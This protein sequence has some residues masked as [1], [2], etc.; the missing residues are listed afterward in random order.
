M[1][2]TSTKDRLASATENLVAVLQKTHPS[3]PFLDQGTKTNDAIQEL[4]KIFQPQQ[5]DNNVESSSDLG[6]VFGAEIG[7]DLVA[8]LDAALGLALGSELGSGLGSGL[9]SLIGIEF[10]TGFVTTLVMELG[11]S[12][13]ITSI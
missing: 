2:R 13:I 6:L 10:V 8:K 4:Q 7:I 11:N 9:R 3:T 12:C 5:K 1:P